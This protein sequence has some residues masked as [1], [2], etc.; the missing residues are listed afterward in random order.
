MIINERQYRIT[1]AQAQRFREALDAPYP[2]DVDPDLAKAMRDGI[3]SQLDDLAAELQEYE[4]LRDG[5]VAVL[6]VDSIAAIGEALIKARIIRRLTHKELADRLDVAEQQVQRYEAT[7]YRGVSADRLQQV[8][9]AL[10][11]RVREV[12]TL[13]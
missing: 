4:T 2:P 7:N 9:D 3:Q 11:L 12:V 6:E 10:R 1:Q 13:E 5:H 8:A